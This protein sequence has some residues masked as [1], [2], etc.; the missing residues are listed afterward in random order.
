MWIFSCTD[1]DFV[2]DAEMNYRGKDEEIRIHQKQPIGEIQ[3]IRLNADAPR[4]K[5]YKCDK[6][7]K[8]R[9]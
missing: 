8:R 1:C 4:Y 7:A 2:T 6:T 5:E 3:A 9:C